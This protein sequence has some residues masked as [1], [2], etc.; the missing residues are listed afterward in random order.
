MIANCNVTTQHSV[1]LRLAFVQS[2]K[3]HKIEIPIEYETKKKIQKK[4]SLLASELHI[5]MSKISVFRLSL[6]FFDQF[7]S[8]IS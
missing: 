3:L 2:G 7:Y 5:L 4:N 1:K 6:Q 8:Y